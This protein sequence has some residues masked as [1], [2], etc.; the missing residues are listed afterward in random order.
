MPADTSTRRYLLNGQIA[1][2]LPPRIVC[3]AIARSRLMM[4][5]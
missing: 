4:P 1:N 3:V 2:A 5:A